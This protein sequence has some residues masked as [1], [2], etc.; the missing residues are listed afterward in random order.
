MKNQILY[1]ELGKYYDLIYS[2]KDYK[3]E[4]IQI[5]KLISKYK[6]SDGKEL[7][8]VACGTGNHLKYLQSSFS[9][10]GVD[11]NN[12]VLDI[13]K[14]NVKNVTF[15]KADMLTLNLKKKFDIILCLFS[16]IGYVKTYSNLRKTI[17]NFARHLKNG[18]VVVIEPWYT[19]A[20]FK[21]G[22]PHMTTYKGKDTKIARLNVSKVKDNISIIDMH[23]LIAEK[24]KDVKHFVDRHK[25]GLFEINKTL[26]IMEEADLQTKFLKK[27]L[28][29]DRGIY[30]GIKK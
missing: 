30:V 13:A 20:T 12:G 16:S 10:I 6:K 21:A 5:K 17:H 28:M 1:K 7:L 15:K 3:K 4:A 11:I 25:L 24:N 26:K 14:R 22:F 8:E 18:G 23:Y 2:W 29:K 19:K 27:G 9:C